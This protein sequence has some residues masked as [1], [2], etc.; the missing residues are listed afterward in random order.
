[1]TFVSSFNRPNL[2]YEVRF[3]PSTGG[4]DALYENM[5][6]FFSSIYKKRQQRLGATSD[7]RNQGVCGIIYCA[8]RQ[9]CDELAN[10]L[11][12]DGVHARSYHAGLT[13]NTRKAILQAWTRTSEKQQTTFSSTRNI[14][15]SSSSSSSSSLFFD[16]GNSNKNISPYTSSSSDTLLQNIKNGK[17]STSSNHLNDKSFFFDGDVILSSS[18]SNSIATS[19]RAKIDQTEPPDDAEIVDIVVATISFGMGID[20]KDVRFVIHWDMPKSL[21]AYYQESGRAGRDGKISR[22][23]LYYSRDDRDRLTFLLQ[24]QQ[25]TG[26][27]EAFSSSGS[28]YGSSS[29][30][31][32]HRDTEAQKVHTMECFNKVINAERGDGFKV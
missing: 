28:S 19:A 26:D 3:K 29:T 13:N 23:I 30:T 17:T 20:R 4:Q 6:T 25:Q 11:S 22:C 32:R 24:Q 1:M 31:T 15:R 7:I 2:H 18:D 10:R 21:E 5:L 8:T 16:L 14:T 27:K 12:R 9:T